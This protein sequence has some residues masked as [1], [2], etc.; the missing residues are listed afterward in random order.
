MYLI[1]KI[2]ICYIIAFQINRFTLQTHD[3]VVHGSGPTGR[4]HQCGSKLL[5][6]EC[7]FYFFFFFIGNTYISQVRNKE[8]MGKHFS[9]HSFG[10]KLCVGLWGILPSSLASA[11]VLPSHNS[12]LAGV[13]YLYQ[14]HITNEA[15][16]ADAKTAQWETKC[17]CSWVLLKTGLG[18]SLI[19]GI[20]KNCE[21]EHF[22]FS[23]LSQLE[24]PP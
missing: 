9:I 13:L 19:H 22:S 6:P 8:K 21:Q 24:A 20:P 18:R 5:S 17:R 14:G 1:Q 11:T 10:S 2:K 7:S 12:Q 23:S 3:Q 15:A 16:A 4:T